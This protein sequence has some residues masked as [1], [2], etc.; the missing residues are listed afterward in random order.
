[1]LTLYIHQAYCTALWSS[2][3]E[4]YTYNYYMFIYTPWQT[5]GCD[6]V[7]LGTPILNL[8][9]NCNFSKLQCSHDKID[10]T[11]F[12]VN[13]KLSMPTLL[14]RIQTKR[15]HFKIPNSQR[16]LRYGG[17]HVRLTPMKHLFVF[18]RWEWNYV[19][20][21]NI[22]FVFKQFTYTSCSE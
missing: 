19:Q 18:I 8:R 12:T 20:Y 7:F 16:K 11:V 4:V 14:W 10:N 3:F 22:K 6:F 15:H 2:P 13:T 1:M 21:F 17:I 5:I 9:I